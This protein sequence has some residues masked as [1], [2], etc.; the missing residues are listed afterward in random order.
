MNQKAGWQKYLI[1]SLGK[2]KGL[3]LLSLVLALALWFAVGGEERIETSVSLTLELV[4]IPSDLIVTNEISPQIE[5]RIQ[6]PHSVAREL[7]AER[8]HK[9]IDLTG[10]KSGNHVFPL[11]PSSLNFPRGVVVTRIRPSSIAV[12]LDQAII[13]HLEIR[14]VIKGKPA[15]DYEL[16][17]VNVVPERIEIKGPKSE[18]SQLN[19]LNTL[20]IEISHL[21]SSVTREVDLDFQNLHLSYVSHR[22]VLAELEILPIKK[23]KVLTGIKIVPSM[24]SGTVQLNP[25]QVSLTVRGPAPI[26]NDLSADDVSAMVDLQNLKPGRHQVQV[27]AELPAGLKLMLIQPQTVQVRLDK[28]TKKR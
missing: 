21:S 7:A 25:P 4:N 1:T 14:P 18:L 28:V 10:Y 26:I 16:T 13:R 27:K 17:K 20:P 23:T 3:K 2:N 8:L 12:I 9:R 11:S 15:P 5:V 19:Y 6:G 24:A 22:P